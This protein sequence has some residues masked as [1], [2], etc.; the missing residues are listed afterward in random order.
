M[1]DGTNTEGTQTKYEQI[2][3]KADVRPETRRLFILNEEVF[4][5]II[6]EMARRVAC[7]DHW[8]INSWTDEGKAAIKASL[9]STATC[10][11]I[12]MRQTVGYSFGGYT[13]AF[14]VTQKL[15]NYHYSRWQAPSET[16]LCA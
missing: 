15:V 13:D 11:G 1:S 7:E 3:A 14:M 4:S 6:K 5:L 8:S 10:A 9:A 2:V 12:M 16:Y